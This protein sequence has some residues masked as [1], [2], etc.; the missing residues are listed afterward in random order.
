MAQLSKQ[1][2]I[3]A[4]NQYCFISSLTNLFNKPF[5]RL[6][7][8]INWTFLSLKIIVDTLTDIE[9]DQNITS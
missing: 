4:E 6:I 5:K 9:K 3:G 7:H 1:V 2:T 8:L